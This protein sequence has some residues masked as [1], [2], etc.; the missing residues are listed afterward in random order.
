MG[1]KMDVLRVAFLSHSWQ[2]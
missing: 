2:L 1:R